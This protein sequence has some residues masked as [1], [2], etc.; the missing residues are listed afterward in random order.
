MKKADVTFVFLGD[1]YYGFAKRKLNTGFYSE[2][3]Y[4]IEDI[5]QMMIM[6][7][8]SH[9]IRKGSKIDLGKGKDAIYNFKYVDNDLETEKDNKA[10]I[11]IR[12]PGKQREKYF[13]KEKT[14]DSLASISSKLNKAA[15]VKVIALATTGLTFMTFATIKLAKI[16]DIEYQKN[17]EKV[18]SYVQELK[19]EPYVSEYD[20]LCYEIKELETQIND[21]KIPEISLEQNKQKLESMKTAKAALEASFEQNQQSTIKSK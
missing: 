11:S 14:L 19:Q 20:R 4:S 1:N 7:I 9:E 3:V 2:E 13:E 6:G 8:N 16:A 5:I 15:L 17:S 21:G 18:Q 10:Q 12:I